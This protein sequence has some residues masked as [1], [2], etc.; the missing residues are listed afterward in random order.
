MSGRALSVS[1][2]LY[3]CPLLGRRRC[4]ATC[5]RHGHS[6]SPSSRHHALNLLRRPRHSVCRRKSLAGRVWH[7]LMIRL[8]AHVAAHCMVVIRLRHSPTS[9]LF[10]RT[11]Q[12]LHRYVEA[13]YSKDLFTK[14]PLPDGSVY[15]VT[16]DEE[17]CLAYGTLASARLVDCKHTNRQ[18]QTHKHA[19]KCACAYTTIPASFFT[20]VSCIIVQP[21]LHTSLAK[22]PCSP[23]KPTALPAV[24]AYAEGTR[25]AC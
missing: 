18:T 15:N 14:Y 19:S 12:K 10:P 21:P 11:L 6:R 24:S 25:D 1:I 2:V 5:C 4:H 16:L 23:A 20:H 13:E 8:R 22:P 7:L 3:G 9:T 17:K